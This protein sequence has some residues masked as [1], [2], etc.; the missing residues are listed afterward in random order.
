MKKIVRLTESDLVG[1]IRRIIKEDV[2]NQEDKLILI[3]NESS[4]AVQ[5]L[6]NNLPETIKFLA[7]TDCEGADFSGIDMCSFPEL[8]VVNL[9]GTPNNFEDVVECDYYTLSDNMFEFPQNY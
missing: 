3:R 7:I 8:L 4:E 5:E 1:L 6:L 9:K 2:D